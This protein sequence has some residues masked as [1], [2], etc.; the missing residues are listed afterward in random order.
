MA[1]MTPT[2]A[3]PRNATSH[4]CACRHQLSWRN[5]SSVFT[6]DFLLASTLSIRLSNWIEFK[7]YLTKVL[8]ATCYG[9]TLMIDVAGESPLEAQDTLSDKTS[10][11]SSTIRTT[12]NWLQGLISWWWMGITGVKNV[13]LWPSSQLPTT[14]TDVATK[15]PSWKSTSISS[16]P[17]KSQLTSSLQFDP[18][19]RNEENVKTKRTPDYFL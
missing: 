7:K 6:E 14:V 2:C 9:R 1:A 4:A 19:P 8:C 10:L 3:T 12:S 17:C 16:T 15:Q 11:S 18:S 5:R 13:T